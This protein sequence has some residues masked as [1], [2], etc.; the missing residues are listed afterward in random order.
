MEVLGTEWTTLSRNMH[1]RI[2][3]Y[4]ART[5]SRGGLVAVYVALSLTVILGVTA[6]ALDGGMLL[7]ERRHAQ[8][9]AD[10]AAL[11][12][13]G[14]LYANYQ[15]N[16]GLD[17]SG[18][19][20]SSAL[21]VA[22]ANGYANDG[23][24]S[25]VTPNIPPAAG[26]H[27]GQP[28]YVEVIVQFNQQRAFSN[29]WGSS[30]L[31]VTARAVARGRWVHSPPG[32]LVLDYSGK[33]TFNVQGGGAFTETGAAVI[34]NS[35]NP[36][37]LVDLGTGAA[38]AT[39]FDITGNLQVGNK[40]TLQTAP[41]P[42]QFNE[43]VPSTPDPLAYLPAPGQPGAPPIPGA[44]TITTAPNPAGGT[45]YTLSPG[46][47]GSPLGPK[48]PNFTGSDV[49]ILMQASAGNNGIY[50]L[51]QGGLNFSGA[52][53]QMDSNTSGGVMIYN[54]G[55]GTNDKISITGSSGGTVNLSPLTSGIYQGLSFFQARNATEDLQFTGNG[56]FNIGGT[57]YAPNATLKVTGNGGSASVGSQW[58]FKDVSIAGNGI[59]QLT[60]TPDSVARTRF[61]GLVE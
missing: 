31:P 13:A 60:Y 51:N 33:G 15:Q 45:I 29:I 3:P 17:P 50:Y 52:T 47:Y 42:N 11:A 35:N 40:A 28:G 26:D 41:A 7:A 25:I 56:T 59:V 5:K 8:A 9:T 55:T 27:A 43:G 1:M 36:Q 4:S 14:D 53:M 39:E 49:V 2:S 58:I 12:A 24:T 37:A 38:V 32:V 10:A 20:K 61:I 57:F 19:A 21:A 46:A 48:L 34:V 22:N 44:G 16:F 23:T 54:A 6:I 30:A 18:T